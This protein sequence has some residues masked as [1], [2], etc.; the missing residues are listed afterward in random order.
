MRRARLTYQ[1]AYHHI[2]NRGIKDE[3]IFAGKENKS[4]FTAALK[5]K[6]ELHRIK[7]L[8]YCIMNNHYHLILQNTTG[9]IDYFMKQLN[10]QYGTYYRKK[11][12]G[13]G[14]V[15]QNRY[16][17]T[18]IQED[19]YL[20]TAI[21]YTLMNP[22]RAGIVKSPENYRW[23]SYREYM[24]TCKEETSLVDTAET[25]S[26]FSKTK[27]TAMK[28]YREFVE[29]GISKEN[30]P[31]EEVEAGIILGS[32]KF[33]TTIRRLLNRMK[34]DEEIPQMKSLREK[35]SIDKVIKVCCNYYAKN[36][37]ELLK[38]GKG[39]EERRAAIYLSK[40]LSN[41]KNVEIGRYFRIKGSTVSEALKGVEARIKRDV[42]FQKEIEVL[43]EK[44]VIEQ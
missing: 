28:A 32:E 6:A 19:R 29:A 22:V 27:N 17:S 44:L 16:K 3:N 2:M 39:K 40:I 37:E 41:E 23:T 36:K 11:N 30:N 14:Y 10:A 34:P 8:A 31:F 25:L 1:G 33:K 18:L 42:N 24:G 7:L 4:Y 5:E 15:F 13:R 9:R 12:G 20:K 43:K 35:V 26:Y 38:K 21:A